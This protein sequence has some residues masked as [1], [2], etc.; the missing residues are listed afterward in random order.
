[1]SKLE[2]EIRSYI[3]IFGLTFII[4]FL[5]GCQTTE[6][7]T[8]T[9]EINLETKLEKIEN[10]LNKIEQTIKK[11]KK[12]KGFENPFE[13]EEIA[14]NMTVTSTKP[15]VCGRIDI[16][17]TNME[18]KFG[19]VP[20]F[21]GKSESATPLGKHRHMVTLTYNQKTESFTFF[22]QMPLEGRLLCMLASGKGKLNMELLKGTTL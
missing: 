20:V 8:S 4:A 14:P 7:A 1:M 5:S 16:I 10:E 21:V 2:L 9:P 13:G 17:L 3:I 6:V 15:V 11:D 19:E 12:E 18:N 22:E